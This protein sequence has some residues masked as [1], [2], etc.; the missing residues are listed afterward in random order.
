MNKS[1]N[2]TIIKYLILPLIFLTVSLLGGLRLS[3]E[4]NSFLFLKP[5]LICLIF[6]TIL[7]ILL[8]RAKL[9][10]ISDWVSGDASILKNSSAV[11][12]LLTLFAA[13]AQ[14]FNSLLPEKGLPSG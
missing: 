1:K 6:A 4:N 2:Q 11:I 7:V 9:I 13:T 3:F 12:V 14:I 5:A 10:N 8:F